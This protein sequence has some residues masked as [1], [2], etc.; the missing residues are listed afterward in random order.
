MLDKNNNSNKSN[1]NKIIIT[2]I[3]CNELHKVFNNKLSSFY[4][5]Q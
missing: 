2:L 1:N 3:E 5:N 4:S